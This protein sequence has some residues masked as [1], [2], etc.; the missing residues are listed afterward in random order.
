VLFEA[1]AALTLNFSMFVALHS[2]YLGWFEHYLILT[3]RLKP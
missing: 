3:P 2:L 1:L